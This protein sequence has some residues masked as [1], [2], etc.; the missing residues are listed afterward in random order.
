[1]PLTARQAPVQTLEDDTGEP[2]QDEDGENGA[3]S[4]AGETAESR[5]PNGQEKTYQRNAAIAFEAPKDQ[6][7]QDAQKADDGDFGQSEEIGIHLP[8]RRH[9]HYVVRRRRMIVRHA[10]PLG[11]AVKAYRRLYRKARGFAT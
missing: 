4:E 11:E 7:Q 8:V 2:E 10:R 3:P 5:R 6:Q 1:M 9:V